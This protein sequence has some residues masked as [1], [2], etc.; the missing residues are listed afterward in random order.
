MA[1][2]VGVLPCRVRE[3]RIEVL[4][5]TSRLDGSWGLI[6]RSLP[7]KEKAQSGEA[8]RVAAE[9][10]FKAC[11]VRGTCRP[12][13]QVQARRS[14]GALNVGALN[15]VLLRVAREV[16]RYPERGKRR[17]E[18]L[19]VGQASQRLSAQPD[20]G[21]L[22]AAL[23]VHDLPTASLREH[24]APWQRPRAEQPVICLDLDDTILTRGDEPMPGATAACEVLVARGCRLV[25]STA[26][27]D[28][29]WE[30][31][32]RADKI[33]VLL[34]DLGF[35]IAELSAEIPPADLYVDDKGWR[36]D[37]DWDALLDEARGRLVARGRL[38][39]SLALSGCLMGPDE[40]PLE[41]AREALAELGSLGVERIV[42]LGNFR[43]DLSG[44]ERLQAARDW[45]AEAGIETSRVHPGKISS[46]LYVDAHAFRFVDR[47]ERALPA[48][49]GRL[50]REPR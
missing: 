33:R 8:E 49:L 12:L 39:L 20:L 9:A 14:K 21:A 16:E 46:H 27:L 15:V 37:G 30:G 23:T 4:L 50:L 44:E 7:E 31:S 10:A 28:P 5:V 35:P 29:V 13:C 3:G 36:F 17:R 26:R 24:P 43:R 34:A 6:E 40:G 32:P 1:E 11:G 25:A 18:W 22:V 47:W 41:G 19:P 38:R 48:I 45:L 42:S 2:R